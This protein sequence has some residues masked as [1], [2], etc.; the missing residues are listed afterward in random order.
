MAIQRV[1]LHGRTDERIESLL[2]ARLF[3]EPRLADGRLYF[4]SSLSG[5]LS[6]FAMDAGGG[7]PE[8]L[9]PPQIALQNPELIGGHS[10]DVL[11]FSSESSTASVSFSARGRVPMGSDSGRSS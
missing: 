8:P 9:L 4:I 1:V 7:V 10:F 2:S 3:L 11:P 5:H 6:L